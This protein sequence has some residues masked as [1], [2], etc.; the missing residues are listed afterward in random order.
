MRC[1]NK[2]INIFRSKIASIFNIKI[3]YHL[4]IE[5]TEKEIMEQLES[6]KA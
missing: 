4:N 2:I 6:R 1:F 5:V 3:D